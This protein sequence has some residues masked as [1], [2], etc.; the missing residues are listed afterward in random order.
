M[1]IKDFGPCY[2][3]SAP[4]K[5]AEL[6]PETLAQIRIEDD[7]FEGTATVTLEFLPA[8]RIV[9]HGIF[10]AVPL[11][12]AVSV[13]SDREWSIGKRHVR[14]LHVG[15][16]Q[17]FG[18][19][20][21]TALGA[22]PEVGS[23][24]IDWELLYPWFPWS[25]PDDAELS[26]LVFHVFYYGVPRCAGI[27]RSREL[28]HFNPY[29]AEL[30]QY[31]P[32]G[33]CS[34]FE[35]WRIAMN[36]TMSSKSALEWVER[37]GGFLLTHVA[38]IE[39]TDGST[40]TGREAVSLISALELFLTFSKGSQCEPVC[41]VGFDR[42]G[43]RVWTIWSAPLQ[44]APGWEDW[45]QKNEDTDL[46]KDYSFPGFMSLWQD[47]EWRMALPEVID[48]Y[49]DA[50]DLSRRVESGI[51]C[52][53]TALERL[54]FEYCIRRRK[55]LTPDGFRRLS[56]ADQ[57]R[58]LLGCLEIP[59]AI[60][61][62]DRSW[63]P[64]R[65]DKLTQFIEKMPKS[66]KWV[67]APHALTEVRNSVIHPEKKRSGSTTIEEVYEDAWHLGVKL[68]KECILALWG[69]NVY[70]EYPWEKEATED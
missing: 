51:I 63:H 57:I 15:G 8:P 13:A 20:A 58:L 41:P 66:Q 43:N 1:N 55:L 31:R 56:A 9:A 33:F 26:S 4:N 24:A 50:N 45:L 5:P 6:L 22:T 19:V 64:R 59:N 61:E 29:R 3:F 70:G 14:E 35:N 30:R 23:L 11:E 39:R 46:L 34:T 17:F 44:I 68:V 53:Q 10:P 69:Y 12:I 40:F 49:C 28:E 37:R 48:W 52:A 54:A 42:D 67:D 16:K 38:Y 32:T 2:D 7:W 27:R 36:D 60:P 65:Y 21:G 18:F 25:A 62:S 47:Q